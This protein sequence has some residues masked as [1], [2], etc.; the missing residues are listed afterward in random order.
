MN[1]LTA[2]DNPEFKTYALNSTGV[3]KVQTVR[4][5]FNEAMDKLT[6]LGI[7]NTRHASIMRTH[8]EDAS[9]HAIKDISTQSQ[10]QLEEGGKL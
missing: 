5:I 9:M 7:G 8:L 1:N 6:D 10:N 3:R 4:N 2:G